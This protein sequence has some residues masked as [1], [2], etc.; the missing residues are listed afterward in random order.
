VGENFA[1][2]GCGYVE[3]CLPK[4]LGSRLPPLKASSLP[5]LVVGVCCTD[6]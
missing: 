5:A 4:S 2:G 3:V 6:R 1:V